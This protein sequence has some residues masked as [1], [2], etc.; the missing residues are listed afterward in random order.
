MKQTKFTD[1][2]K[3]TE[4]IEY[5]KGVTTQKYVSPIISQ[6]RPRANVVRAANS[7]NVR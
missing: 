4:T 6:G 7:D 5:R 3:V 1:R 2:S